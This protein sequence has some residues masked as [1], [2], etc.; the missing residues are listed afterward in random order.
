MPRTGH[1]GV[2][3]AGRRRCGHLAVVHQV[4]AHSVGCLEC[5]AGGQAWTGLC[6]CLSCGWVACSDDSPNWHARAHYVET[7]HPI[8]AA[9]GTGP[10]PW[11]C[12][13]HQR[14]V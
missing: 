2:G 3:V 13:V 5:Q 4:V 12:F 6:L 7:D 10:K 11:W 9:L 1:A 14:V 8:A